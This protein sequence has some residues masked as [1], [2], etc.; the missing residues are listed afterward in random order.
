MLVS[1]SSLVINVSNIISPLCYSL[2]RLEPYSDCVFRCTYCYA[3][4][5]RK[6]SGVITIVKETLREFKA[7][8][9]YIYRKGLN[10][11]PARLATLSDPFQ[12]HEELYKYSL[13]LLKVSL[14]YEYPIIINT[15]SVNYVKTPWRSYIEKLCERNLLVIQDIYINT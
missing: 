12:P 6:L 3:R 8:A 1:M 2:I 15:K 11:I 5:Y 9:K 10:P 4:W 7:L 14:D 13:S